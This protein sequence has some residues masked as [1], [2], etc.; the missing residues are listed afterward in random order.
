MTNSSGSSSDTKTSNL[1]DTETVK[2]VKPSPTLKAGGGLIGTNSN[3][4]HLKGNPHTSHPSS[5]M[6]SISI[7]EFIK[8]L[9]DEASEPTSTIV[10][11]SPGRRFVDIRANRPSTVTV[12]WP[13]KEGT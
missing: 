10:V 4:S 13:T 8:W 12:P 5:T 9:P 2:V 3:L 6:G 7:R 1:G 11:T